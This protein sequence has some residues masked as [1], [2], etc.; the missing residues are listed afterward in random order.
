MVV[1]NRPTL[2]G[3][4]GNE[5]QSSLLRLTSDTKVWRTLPY[6]LDTG[7]SDFSLLN[8]EGVSGLPVN[9][10]TNSRM[11][12]INLGSCGTKA[13]RDELNKVASGKK[14]VWRTNAGQHPWLQL[15]LKEELKVVKVSQHQLPVS[16]GPANALC[17]GEVRVGPSGRPGGGGE[18]QPGV[19]PGLQRG[20]GHPPHWGRDGGVWRR[21]DHH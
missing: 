10:D 18:G 6:K 20:G 17:S 13:W 14:V 9:A 16:P 19:C 4:Y 11:T 3:R 2:I 8:V 15:D 12:K 7:R 5:E 21:W 1:A